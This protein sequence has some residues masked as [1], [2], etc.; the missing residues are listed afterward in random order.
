MIAVDTRV[1]IH[2]LTE[3]VDT[4]TPSWRAEQAR[5]VIDSG[6]SVFIADIV[7][8]EL[9]KALLSIYS[10]SRNDI[11]T[12][13]HSLA[14]HYQFKFEDWVALQSALL[15]YRELPEV[16]LSDCLV[17]RRAISQGASTLYTFESEE[18]LAS[19]NIVTSLRE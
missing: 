9:E 5:R 19:L 17:A 4:Q 18:R 1:L 16:Y 7:I 8:S 2:Y 3:P 12:L 11:A 14:N 15:D 6:K 13:F 10:F